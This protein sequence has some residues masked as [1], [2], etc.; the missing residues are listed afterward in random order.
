MFHSGDDV[1][2]RLLELWALKRFHLSDMRSGN[3]AD[4]VLFVV[5]ACLYDPAVSI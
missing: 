2:G 5:L 3:K 1:E 4:V